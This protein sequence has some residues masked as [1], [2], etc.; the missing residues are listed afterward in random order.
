MSI[1]DNIRED[2]YKNTKEYP[3]YSYYKNLMN[4]GIDRMDEYKEKLEEYGNEN[5]RLEKLFWNDVEE[6]FGTAN[7]SL[8]DSLRSYAY[9]EGHSAGYSEILNVY[10]DLVNHFVDNYKDK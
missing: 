3:S 5:I 7:H 10:H 8:R 1:Y 2:K 4:H 6:E 9:Q